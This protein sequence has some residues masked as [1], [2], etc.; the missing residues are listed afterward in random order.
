MEGRPEDLSVRDSEASEMAYHFIRVHLK[1]KSR[2]GGLK[3]VSANGYDEPVWEVEII[4]RVE[5]SPR[6]TLVIGT[7]TGSIH[8]W[9]PA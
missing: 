2:P 4:D 7:E 8:A 9:R 6:G 3:R 1:D 5:K